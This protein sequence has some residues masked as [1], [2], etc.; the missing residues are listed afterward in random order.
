MPARAISGGKKM[1]KFLPAVA[2]FLAIG[3]A[4]TAFGQGYAWTA[5]T[6]TAGGGSGVSITGGTNWAAGTPVILGDVFK[7]LSTTGPVTYLGIYAGNNAT[8]AGP[9]TV[10]LFDANG[11]QL[12]SIVVFNT[13]PLVNGYYWAQ[14]VTPVPLTVGATYTVADQVNANGWG[15]G[16]VSTP[17]WAAFLYNDYNYTNAPVA[18]PSTIS[19]SGPEYYG[20]NVWVGRLTVPTVPEG[21]ASF[22]YLLLAG[23]VC[24][25]AMFLTSCNGLG[26]RA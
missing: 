21:G 16:P 7:D 3:Y 10:S 18:F 14:V 8:Y 12:T 24:F 6:L 11:N 13:D 25:G 1:K 19:G 2:V 4:S 15:Y 22:L 5:P 17:N 26:S 9:E 20:A 23:G